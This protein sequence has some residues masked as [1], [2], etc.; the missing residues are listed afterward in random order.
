MVKYTAISLSS[1]SGTGENPWNG[2]T[3]TVEKPWPDHALIQGYDARPDANGFIRIEVQNGW[4]KYRVIRKDEFDAYE[5]E[6][7]EGERT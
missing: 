5:C 1:K 3:W 2:A 6:F 4:A 7:V